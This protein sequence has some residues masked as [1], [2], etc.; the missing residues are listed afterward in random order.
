MD[1]RGSGGMTVRWL[2][3][4]GLAKV[5]FTPAAAAPV[6]NGTSR[7]T[8]TFTRPGAYRLMATASDGQLS[9]KAD[10]VVTVR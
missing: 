1:I 7:A 6:T 4:G 5:T 10:V 9:S 3:Y 2:Q 8:A